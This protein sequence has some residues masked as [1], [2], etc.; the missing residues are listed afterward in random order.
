MWFFFSRLCAL[1]VRFARARRPRGPFVAMREGKMRKGLC[2]AILVPTLGLAG[3]CF[4]QAANR[5]PIVAGQRRYTAEMGIKKVFQQKYEFTDPNGDAI[6]IAHDNN[7]TPAGVT[8]KNVP[9]SEKVLGGHGHKEKTL[10]ITVASTAPEGT[11][12][13]NVSGSDV[14]GSGQTTT[15]QVTVEVTP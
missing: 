14:T 8:V 5:P 10:E 2:G 4:A 11:Y 1:I 7:S 6:T 9:E 13:F 3:I 15:L 12:T